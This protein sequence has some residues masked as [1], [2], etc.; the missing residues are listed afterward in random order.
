MKIK[1]ILALSCLL[2]SCSSQAIKPV[3]DE[4]VEKFNNAGLSE[5]LEY[6]TITGKFNG[7][8]T[9]TLTIFPF[10]GYE[11]E[12]GDVYYDNWV[13]ISRNGTVAPMLF[14]SYRPRLIFEGDLDGNGT[15]EFA[16]LGTG[17]HGCTAAYNVYTTDFR[18]PTKIINLYVFL[19]YED[20]DAALKGFVSP[21]DSKGK[22]NLNY[23]RPSA[24]GPEPVKKSTSISK[25]SD[26]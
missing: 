3:Y 21:G 24:E 1:T 16:L 7:D 9:D 8:D 20:E 12:A 5:P 13:L 23:L 14:D 19:D 6:Y 18:T 17:Q 25:A 22:V 26:F 11:D 15:D 2:C 4:Y 10:S